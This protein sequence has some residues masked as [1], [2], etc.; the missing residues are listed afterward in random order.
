MVAPDRV[1]VSDRAAVLDHGIEGGRLD[2]EPLHIQFAM[3]PGGVK[4]EIR[5]RAVRIDMGAAA[6]YLASTAVASTMARSVAALTLSWNDSNRSQVIAV[7]NVSL[8]MPR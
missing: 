2:G 7:S 3:P 8:M 4:G 1:M 6:R 5:R